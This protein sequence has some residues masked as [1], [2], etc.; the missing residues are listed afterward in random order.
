M[1]R[2]LCEYLDDNV[3][4]SIVAVCDCDTNIHGEISAGDTTDLVKE[5]R[6]TKCYSNSKEL[7]RTTTYYTVLLVC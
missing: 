1:V 6:R 7:L 5:H 4:Y 3:Q 2:R